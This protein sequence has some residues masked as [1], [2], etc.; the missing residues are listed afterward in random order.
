GSRFICKT[1]C[2][3]DIPAS[4]PRCLFYCAKTHQPRVG[5]MEKPDTTGR[6]CENGGL[7]PCVR[8]CYQGE[9]T[10]INSNL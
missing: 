6:D 5:C 4:L 8:W 9:S 10:R 7:M 1:V 2:V 3:D